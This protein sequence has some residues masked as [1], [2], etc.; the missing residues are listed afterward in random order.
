MTANE[1]SLT[2]SQY[3][4]Y[5]IG[6]KVDIANKSR[7]EAPRGFSRSKHGRTVAT[8]L[9]HKCMDKHYDGIALMEVNDNVKS[10]AQL[11][12][13]P[14]ESARDAQKRVNFN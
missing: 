14:D 7:D 1:S 2:I 5:S 12:F 8:L 13:W 6:T 10:E 3:G 11:H 4:S 9:I